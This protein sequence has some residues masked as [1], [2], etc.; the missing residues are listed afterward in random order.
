MTD[1]LADAI[2]EEVRRVVREELAGQARAPRL[3]SVS[4]TAALIG[5]SR[6]LYYRYVTSGEL[7][8]TR[9]ASRRLISDAAIADFIE[10]KEVGRAA[11]TT[12]VQ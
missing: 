9:L 6:A 2:R 4:E 12:S 3:H 10:A 1:A 5:V 11:A 8:S 7:R